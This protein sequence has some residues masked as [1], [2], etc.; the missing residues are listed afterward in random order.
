MTVQRPINPEI[1]RDQ[2]VADC[3]IDLADLFSNTRRAKVVFARAIICTVL[4][5]HTMLSLPEIN[6]VIRSRK[7]SHA[8]VLDAIERV[9]AG[10]H[11]DDAKVVTG[12]PCTAL[13]YAN[14]C[15]IRAGEASLVESQPEAAHHNQLQTTRSHGGR[16]FKPNAPIHPRPATSPPWPRLNLP[17]KTAPP[18]SMTRCSSLYRSSPSR[19][20]RSSAR[21]R[22][23]SDEES[24]SAPSLAPYNAQSSGVQQCRP[25]WAGP[26][27]STTSHPTLPETPIESYQHRD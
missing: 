26:N 8:I 19:P 15:F 20:G 5:Q 1:L 25:S 9:R 3:G 23:S 11:D 17:P 2:V 6:G 24:T 18:L 12:L 16:V 10:G 21:L 22:H 4:R 13:E 27:P 7:S 14:Y